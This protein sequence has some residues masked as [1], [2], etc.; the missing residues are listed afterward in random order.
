[1]TATPELTRARSLLLSYYQQWQTLTD[2]EGDAIRSGDWTKVERLQITKQQLQKFIVAA[3]GTLR[4]E[5]ESSGVNLS[6]IERE[7]YSLIGHLVRL[8]T[9]NREEIATRRQQADADLALLKSCRHN[10]HQIQRAYAPGRD[11]IWQSYS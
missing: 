9:Q 6:G 4:A 8:E 1:M 3:T 5:A 11:A 2:A 7:F 10:L